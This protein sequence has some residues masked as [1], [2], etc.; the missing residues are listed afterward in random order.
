[1]KT[2]KSFIALFFLL[3]VGIINAQTNPSD[4]IKTSIQSVITKHDGTEYIG[5]IISD[6]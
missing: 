3:F 4:S 5:T 1:M 6:D 2:I